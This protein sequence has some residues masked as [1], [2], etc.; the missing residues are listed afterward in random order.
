MMIFET[1]MLI[2]RFLIHVITA[3]V[4]VCYMG[5][6]N[7]QRYGIAFLASVLAGGSAALASQILT[8]WETL[9]QGSVEPWAPITYGAVCILV[10]ACRGN[11]AK[12]FDQINRLPFGLIPWIKK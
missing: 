9:V 12:V 6:P 5:N 7:R 8:Q 11:L 2:V 4:I 3:G 10:I 1:S